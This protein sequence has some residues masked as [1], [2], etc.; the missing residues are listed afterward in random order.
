MPH[1]EPCSALPKSVNTFPKTD[2]DKVDLR[3]GANELDDVT[4]A[5]AAVR[6]EPGH[7]VRRLLSAPLAA[8]G[9]AEVA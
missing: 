8:P 3:C 2:M 4:I 9:D 7:Q 5:Q 1:C 6:S